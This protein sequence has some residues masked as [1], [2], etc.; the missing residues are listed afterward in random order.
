MNNQPLPRREDIP[1]GKENAI[2]REELEIL[3]DMSDRQ[4]RKTIERF[5]ESDNT[6]PFPILSTSHSAGYW[7]SNDRDELEHYANEMDAKA[8]KHFLAA[9][10]AKRA[11]RKIYT[12]GQMTIEG[13]LEKETA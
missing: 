2:L 12:Q 6:D 9:Q 3:W 11:L 5:R 8:R 4:V 10:E 1:I 13:L 7:R